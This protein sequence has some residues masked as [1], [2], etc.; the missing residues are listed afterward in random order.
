MIKQIWQTFIKNLKFFYTYVAGPIEADTDDGGQKWRDR[1]T[2]DLDNTGIYVQDPCHTEPLATGMDVVEAQDQFNKWIRS[3]HYDLFAEKFKMIVDK[4]IR[5]VKRSDFIIVHLF[6]EIPTTG[7]IHEMAE[8]WRLG[9]PIYLIWPVAK[10]SLSKWALYL[11]TSSRG[12]IFDNTKQ[13]ADYL[14]IICDWKRQSLRI[15]ILQ[16]IKAIFRLIEEAKYNRKLEK[17]KCKKKKE[18]EKE[19]V[20]DEATN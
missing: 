5:M 6:P 17:K 20:K 7:T 16:F 18:K 3:G 4:D 10:S 1:I 14:S 19:E 11:T 8:A 2:P 9:K 13:C 15:Q 12:K